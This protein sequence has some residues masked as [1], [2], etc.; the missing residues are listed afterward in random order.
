MNREDDARWMR[1]AIG[2]ARQGLGKTSPNPAVGAVIVKNG[3]LL[4]SG[5]HHA[6]GKPHAEIEALRALNSPADAR[7]ATLYV[8]LEPCSTHGRTPPC[9]EAV[10]AAGI[11][12]VVVGAVDP[13]PNHAGQGLLW[14][15]AQGIEIVQGVLE[16]ECSALNEPFNK[17]IRT[18]IPLVIAKAAMSLDG[19]ITRAP[20][21]P[22]AISGEAS[23]R[24]AHQLRA[25]VDAI[26]VGAETVRRDNPRLTVRGVEDARQP[27]R[28]VLTRSGNLPH[29]AHLFTDEFADRTEVF[30]GKSLEAVLHELGHQ[31]VTS[32]LIEGGGE[33]LGEAFDRRL[34]DRVHWYVAPWIIGGDKP[35]VAGKGAGSNEEAIKVGGIRYEIIGDRDVFVSGRVEYSEIR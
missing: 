28:V 34:V 29:D 3:A 31:K 23:H 12:R 27:R 11:S 13:N 22:S 2:K 18:R 30:V 32:V 7:G 1:A 15:E 24:H 9:T 35:A 14:L 10:A 5:Y 8:T 17:W 33:V 4:A 26:L 16:E 25:Q 20:G 21:K 6:A 19:R